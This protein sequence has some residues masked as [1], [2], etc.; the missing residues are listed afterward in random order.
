MKTNIKF[1]N[2]AHDESL[3]EYALLKVEAFGKLVSE[4]VFEGAVCTIEFRKSA[5]HKKGDVCYAEATLRANGK[6]YRSS[7]EEPTLRK[8]IDKVKDDILRELRIDKKAV[9]SERI[10]GASEIKKHIREI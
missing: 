4:Q 9:H 1:T 8:A 10:R 7:K 5:H 3:K 6:T 2:T